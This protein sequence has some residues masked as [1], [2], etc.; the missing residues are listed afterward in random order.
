[1]PAGQPA[2]PERYTKSSMMASRII[3]HRDGASVRLIP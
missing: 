3:A 1:M 2:L